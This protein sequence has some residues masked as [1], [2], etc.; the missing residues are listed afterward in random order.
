MLEN[1]IYLGF[2]DE[3]PEVYYLVSEDY[4]LVVR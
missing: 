1:L 2:T 3:I 4:L